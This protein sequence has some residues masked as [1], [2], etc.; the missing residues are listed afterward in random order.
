MLVSDLHKYEGVTL[1]ST[2]GVATEVE[3][4]RLEGGEAGLR[5]IEGTIFTDPSKAEVF[6]KEYVSHYKALI[7]TDD[8]DRSRHSR[9]MCWKPPRILQAFQ[10]RT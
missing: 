10:R 2:A 5:Q 6:L 4:G 9:P 8:K 1:T 7:P 3:L